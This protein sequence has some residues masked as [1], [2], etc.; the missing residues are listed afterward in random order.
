MFGVEANVDVFPADGDFP[1]LVFAYPQLIT[2]DNR[3]KCDKVFSKY[4]NTRSLGANS[5]RARAHS[6]GMPM[7]VGMGMP[8]AITMSTK[9]HIIGIAYGLYDG[10]AHLLYHG[11]NK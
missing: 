4:E 9:K 5:I 8:V 1:F 6:H 10:H 11:H 2:T 3:W 7:T